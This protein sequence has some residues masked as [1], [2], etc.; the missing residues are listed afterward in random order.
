MS[1]MMVGV[2]EYNKSQ[3]LSKIGFAQ[4]SFPIMYLG[5]PLSSKKWSKM[6]YHQPTE[7]STSRIT[8]VYSKLLLY[9]GQ[10]SVIKEVDKTCRAYLWGSF[11]DKKKIRLVVWDK[12]CVPKK[13]GGLNI[14]GSKLWNV[15]SVAMDQWSLALIPVGDVK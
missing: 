15:A 9:A 14:K 3:P 2:D 8:K 12:V 13:F 5:I 10:E 7:K 6:E 1:R 11:E 4:G